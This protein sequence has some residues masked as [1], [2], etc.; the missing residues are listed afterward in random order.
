MNPQTGVISGTPLKG[1]TVAYGGVVSAYKNNAYDAAV[2]D[3]TL[4]TDTT[5]PSPATIPT[6]GTWARIMM[7]FMMVIAGV[8]FKKNG[9]A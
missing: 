8:R 3:I 5:P 4:A 2:T 7:M 1:P 6:L 9:G